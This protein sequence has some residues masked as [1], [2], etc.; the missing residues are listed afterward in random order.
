MLKQR[1][2]TAV[3]LLPLVLGALLL[4]PIWLVQALLA[5]S[6][7]LADRKSVV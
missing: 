3:I 1:I 2:I 4:G 6:M 7:L 5:I